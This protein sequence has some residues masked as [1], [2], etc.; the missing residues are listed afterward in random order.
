MTLVVVRRTGGIAGQVL[1][2]A[3]DLDSDDPRA[4]EAR[5]LVGTI[6]P[7]DHAGPAMPLP[8]MYVYTLELPSGALLVPEHRLTGDLRSLVELVLGSL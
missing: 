3:L 4:A 6:D 2:G 1:E 5:D 7:A 8:D